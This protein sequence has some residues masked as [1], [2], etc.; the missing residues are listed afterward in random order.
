MIKVSSPTLDQTDGGTVVR[1]TIAG[2]RFEYDL[3]FE[4]SVSLAV[5]FSEPFVLPAVLAGMGDGEPVE[6][7]VPVSAAL[8]ERLPDI[9]RILATWYPSLK[10]IE[11]HAPVDASDPVQKPLGTACFFSGG[12]DSFATVVRH[13]AGL[14]G[15]LLIRGSDVSLWNDPQWA[16]VR[17]RSARAADQLGLPLVT[18]ATNIRGLTERAGAWNT[19]GHGAGLAAVGLLFQDRYRS[20]FIASSFS[21]A[22]LFPWG[23]HPLLDP[24]FSTERTAVIHDGLE[25]SRQ[26]KIAF[27]AGHSVAMRHLRV[28]IRQTGAYNCGNCEKCLR[29][30]VGL[31]LAGALGRCEG[32]P[33]STLP[34][35]RLRT[36]WIPD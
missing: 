29:T 21:I 20:V 14:T 12:V 34:I 5:P 6:I 30:A 13:K 18:V 24:L 22:D 28:C 19:V 1:A 7:Q 17:E 16:V 10:R 33:Y 27:I 11:V 36:L 32:F 2:T 4:T 3:R 35:E 15:L 31:H 25:L 23:S 8:L 26:D 9:Q